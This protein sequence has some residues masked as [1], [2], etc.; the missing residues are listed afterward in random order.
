MDIQTAFNIAVM[1]V[2]GLGGWIINSITNQ[3]QTLRNTDA[4]MLDKIQHTEVLV[5]GQYVRN[6]ALDK[7][8]LAIFTKLD[9]IEGKLDSKQD[10]V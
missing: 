6:E 7:M 4:A 1:L 5:A 3:L 8:S 10:K 2:G 9:R